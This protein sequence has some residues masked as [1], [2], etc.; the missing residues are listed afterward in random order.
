MEEFDWR[1]FLDLAEELVE[2]RNN[3]AADRTAISR[4]YY[5]AFHL[6]SAYVSDRGVRL[7]FTGRDHATVWA[8]FL[9][10]DVAA[11][12]RWIGNAG[13]VLRQARRHADYRPTPFPEPTKEAQ[14]AVRFAMRIVSELNR[15]G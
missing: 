2:R 8:W 11:G 9:G 14:T 5:A 15:V 10:A 7:T 13:S 4:A 3:A 1:A 6:A 12:L